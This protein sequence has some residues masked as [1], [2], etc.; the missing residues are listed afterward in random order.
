MKILN[1]TEMSAAA[2]GVDPLPFPGRERCV[3]PP[4]QDDYWVLELLREEE[5]FEHLF[6]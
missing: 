2:G 6:D 5:S 3:G 1:E 4:E